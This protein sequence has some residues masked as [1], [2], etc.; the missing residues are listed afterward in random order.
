MNQA[1]L[2]LPRQQPLS[3]VDFGKGT[4]SST[5]SS[6]AW[7]LHLLYPGSSTSM[8]LDEYY[9]CRLF[10]IKAPKP[11]RKHGE[12]SEFKLAE[13]EKTTGDGQELLW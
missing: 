3:L 5:S 9:W 12:V 1:T 8:F 4:G 7:Y 11:Q 10:L 13:H 6:L 2:H